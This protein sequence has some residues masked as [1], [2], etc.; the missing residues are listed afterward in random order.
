[1]LDSSL[2]HFMACNLWDIKMGNKTWVSPQAPGTQC[3][4]GHWKML[5]PWERNP[6]TWGLHPALGCRE[7]KGKWGKPPSSFCIPCPAG[8]PKYGPG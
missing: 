7:W 2:S 6:E 5:C 4:A 3:E 1:M 8:M